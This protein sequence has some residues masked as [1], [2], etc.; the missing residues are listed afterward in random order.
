M[1]LL[2]KFRDPTLC[3]NVLEQ[4]RE[5]TEEPFRFMEVC[6]T[7]TVAIFQ[8]GIK[9]LL[10][11]NISHISGPGCPVCVTHDREITAF[12]ELAKKEMLL[13]TF[14]DLMRVPG[15]GGKSL[16]QAQAEGARVQVVYSPFDA[17][18]LALDNPGEKVIFLAVGFETTAP[19]VAATLKVAK[20][21]QVDNF[22]IL[23]MHKL[24]PPALRALAGDRDIRLDGLL[25]PGHVST[26]IGLNPYTFLA[27]EFGLPGVI[28]G[29]EPLDILHSILVLLGQKKKA[30]PEVIN[31]YPR[32]VA[33]KGNPRALSVMQEVFVPVDAWWRGLGNIPG[34]GLALAG[35]Y[36]YFDAWKF[37]DA[38]PESGD[39]ISGCSCGQVLKG[40]VLPD[41]C[42]LFGVKC[43]PAAPIGP[44]MVSSEGACAA[45]FKYSVH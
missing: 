35:D 25:L 43:T 23:G 38:V 30:S 15:P 36:Q 34:S 14:G 42:P 9:T 16:K 10:P 7:H 44:C 3:A 28:S 31:N 6:G 12:L 8:S 40:Q 27:E 1:N 24:V 45:F 22:Y 29:F 17:L 4:I 11:D 41:K 5:E 21:Q 19:T 20:Q 2:D 33:N 13:A 37:L 18:Q 39:R 32:A 26:I